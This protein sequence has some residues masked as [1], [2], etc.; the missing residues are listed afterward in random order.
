MCI[1]NNTYKHTYI[2]HSYFYMKNGVDVTRCRLGEDGNFINNHHSQALASESL[3]HSSSIL[4]APT[5]LYFQYAFPPLGSSKSPWDKGRDFYLH[6][7]DEWIN[8]YRKELT[9]PKAQLVSGRAESRILIAWDFKEIQSREGGLTRP[10]ALAQVSAQPPPPCG[11]E[12][13]GTFTFRMPSCFISMT[14]RV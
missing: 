14:W 7:A 11:M 1:Y 9:C 3:R 4:Y 10:S 6:F 8:S 5:T 12:A 2:F 13:K